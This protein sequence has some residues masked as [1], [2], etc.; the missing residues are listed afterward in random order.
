V[1]V[2]VANVSTGAVPV[3][4]ALLAADSHLA[5]KARRSV[6]PLSEGIWSLEELGFGAARGAEG[7]IEVALSADDPSNPCTMG[8]RE[9]ACADPCNRNV[10]P[11]RYRLPGSPVFI[12]FAVVADTG[13]GSLRYL[14]GLVD[15]VGA[16]RSITE[17]RTSH[18]PGDT[19]FPGLVD[20]LA[21]LLLVR[22]P[23]PSFRKVEPK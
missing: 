6:P 22:E 4:I 8:A 17:Y 1:L 10:C 14:P 20:L 12:A 7:R 16:M 9:P 18:C 13:K 15:Q 19:T 23:P 5:G 11:Q 21:R 2:G 3:E